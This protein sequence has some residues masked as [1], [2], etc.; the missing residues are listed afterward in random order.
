MEAVTARARYACV[1][2]SDKNVSLAVRGAKPGSS[3][4]TEMTGGSHAR[5]GWSRRGW[6]EV[7]ELE[8]EV[9]A[10]LTARPRGASLPQSGLT[11]PAV[12]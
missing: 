8:V 10:Q 1:V 5:R 11:R 9:A 4:L 2:L 12:H 7:V 6:E 3:R